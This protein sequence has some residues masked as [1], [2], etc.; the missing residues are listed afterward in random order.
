M[1]NATN[2]PAAWDECI[3]PGS[4]FESGFPS[5]TNGLGSARYRVRL[6]EP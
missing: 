2:G 1:P 3:R 4:A 5:L 6:S